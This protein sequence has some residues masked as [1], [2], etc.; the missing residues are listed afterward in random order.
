MYFNSCYDVLEMHICICTT[1]RFL[2]LSCSWMLAGWL[3]VIEACRYCFVRCKSKPMCVTCRKYTGNLCIMGYIYFPKLYQGSCGPW[4]NPVLAYLTTGWNRTRQNRKD[5]DRSLGFSFCLDNE[6]KE[7][8]GYTF[9]GERH[10][11]TE[12]QES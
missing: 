8:L 2:T 11:T 3:C 7:I 5:I 1:N 10:C 12:F 6:V 9:K 4:I